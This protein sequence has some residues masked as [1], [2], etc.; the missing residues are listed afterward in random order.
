MP[1]N[2]MIQLDIYCKAKL[3]QL[4]KYSDIACMAFMAKLDAVKDSYAQDRAILLKAVELL[5]K[6]DV[7]GDVT[8]PPKKN[9]PEEES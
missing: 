8:K 2:M 9:K 4:Q 6:P 3:D 5:D 7:Y 1:S